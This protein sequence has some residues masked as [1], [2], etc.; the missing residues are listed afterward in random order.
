MSVNVLLGVG[1]TGAKIVESA[2]YLF[3][4]GLGPNK[5]TVGLID[6]DKA[7][8]NVSRTC[9][10][11]TDMIRFRK[12]WGTGKNQLDWNTSE[13]Q[14]GAVLGRVD[15]EPLFPGNPH[16]APDPNGNTNLATVLNQGRMS[17]EEKLL[18]DMLF[19]PG[20][21]E[22]EM[23]LTQ[24]YQGRAHVGSAAMLASLEQDTGGF[25]TRITQLIQLALQ[26]Q[27]V[28]IFLAGSVFGGTG[29]A[30]FPT[31]A[32]AINRIREEV[33]GAQKNRVRICGALMLPYFGFKDPENPFANV[34]KAKDLLPQ[35]RAALEY[36]DEL[37]KTEAVF[38]ELYVAGWDQNFQLGYHE[39]GKAEQ[40]NPPL[41]PELLS[42]LAAVEFLE[43]GGGSDDGTTVFVSARSDAG[44]IGWADLPFK[45]PETRDP[46]YLRVGQLLRF[47][48]YWRT[49]VEPVIDQRSMLGGLKDPWKKLAGDTDFKTETPDD[50]TAL[51]EL[52]GRT[53]KWAAAMHLFGTRAIPQGARFDIWDTRALEKRID[54]DKPA[55]PVDLYDVL[56]GEQ[57]SSAFNA[58]V[59]VEGRKERWRTAGDLFEDLHKPQSAS[60][61][62][63]GFGRI[64]AAVHN[65]ARASLPQENQA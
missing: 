40:K 47:A 34:V 44:G 21:V 38:D 24:G 56:S 25:C 7:N 42:A 1:G 10:L 45:R 55:D 13:V 4:A 27:E 52:M 37:L 63:A 57:L 12:D 36:Y 18:F 16:W 6:Q 58:L 31:L 15:I 60:A 20:P 8:G 62:N 65:A 50:R 59:T 48:L 46:A 43:H 19:T 33:L 39:P 2:L 51:N 49:R 32:R 9:D 11:V 64:V 29:A 17:D 35:A 61:R 41:P 30:G 23:P 28:R 53:L 26:G 14:G 5:V 54:V 3:L 22:Q